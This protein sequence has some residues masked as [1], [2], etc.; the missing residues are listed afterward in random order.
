[1]LMLVFGSLD[2]FLLFFS[3]SVNKYF[4]HVHLVACSFHKIQPFLI[5]RA[6]V[7]CSCCRSSN[8]TVKREEKKSKQRKNTTD[9]SSSQS[10]KCV[11][12]SF[13]SFLLSRSLSRRS[14]FPLS[15][16]VCATHECEI[17]YMSFDK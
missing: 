16:L 13:L 14:S 3:F 5:S 2:F 6:R 10:V 7:H 9:W 17:K 1:M 11:Q 8:I 4:M 12:F 15:M